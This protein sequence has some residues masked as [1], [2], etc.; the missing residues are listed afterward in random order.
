MENQIIANS[1]LLTAEEKSLLMNDTLESFVAS[2]DR[3][4]IV[5][6]ESNDFINKPLINHEEILIS[7]AKSHA[8]KLT[9]VSELEEEHLGTMDSDSEDPWSR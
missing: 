9:R 6:W 8:H 2:P 5:L 4:E 3:S 1:K 7:E